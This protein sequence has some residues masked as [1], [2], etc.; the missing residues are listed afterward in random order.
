MAKRKKKE[1][2]D[3]VLKILQNSDLVVLVARRL[4][5][6]GQ[7]TSVINIYR[8]IKG[9]LG[10]RQMYDFDSGKAIKDV[11]REEGWFFDKP[12]D[13]PGVLDWRP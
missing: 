9:R 13:I 10:L 12:G 7:K 2:S 3:D 1:L 8:E 5:D 4:Y 11:L 6:S